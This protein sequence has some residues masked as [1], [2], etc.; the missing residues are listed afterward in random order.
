MFKQT[1]SSNGWFDYQVYTGR[2][3]NIDKLNIITKFKGERLLLI[4]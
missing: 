2:E 4:Y 1:N 3:E